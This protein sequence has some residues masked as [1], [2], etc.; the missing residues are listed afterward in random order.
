MNKKLHEYEL[1]NIGEQDDNDS[2]VF[3]KKHFFRAETAEE[4][5]EQY[6]FYDVP[7]RLVKVTG[8]RVIEKPEWWSGN[9]K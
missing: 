7:R 4:H 5:N 1:V 8:G 3:P 6:A 2:P 9:I